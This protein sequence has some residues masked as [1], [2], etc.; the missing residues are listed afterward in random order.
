MLGSMRAKKKNQTLVWIILGLLV[1]G[2]I[3]FGGAGLGGGIIRSVGQVGDEEI[4]TES[5]GQALN[6]AL[7]NLSQQFGR[8]VTAAE[9]Q[10]FG[11]Q[12]Q[13]LQGLLTTAA[14]DNENNRLGISIG[15]QAVRAELLNTSAFQG[16]DGSFDKASYEFALER[17]NLTPS[18]YEVILRKQ[19]ARAFLQAAIVAG[20]KTQGTQTQALL[21]FDRETRDFTWAELTADTLGAPVAAPTDAQIQAQYEATPEAYTAPL[22]RKITYVWLTPD[23][24]ADQ[25][26]V[27]E[28]LIQESY[29]LQSDRFNKPEQRSLERIIFGSEQEAIEAR[30]LLDAGSATFDTIAADRGLA[31]GDLDLGEVTRGTIST[32]A[33]K[34]VFDT[35]AT[36]IVGPVKSSLGPALFRINAILAEDITPYEDARAEILGELAGEAARRLVSELVTDIDDLLAAGD[37]L[38]V[39]ATDTDMQL[40]EISFTADTSDG[41]AAYENFRTAANQSQKGDFPEIVDLADGGIFSLRVDAVIE[42][43]LRPL[44]TVKDQVIADWKRAETLRLLTAKAEQLKTDIEAGASFGSLVTHPEVAAR[45]SAFIEAIPSS[46]ITRIFETGTGKAIVVA[47][48]TSVFVARLTQVNAFDGS[49]EQNTALRD[50]VQKQLDAQLGS[51]LLAVFANA[52]RDTADV[53]INQP[54]INQI[55]TQL[56]GGYAGGGM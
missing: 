42:P 41:I 54:A 36:G 18:E 4:T 25:V 56:T 23:M 12:D 10:A 15:D 3:G 5:Y 46:L 9:A 2:L 6:A 49:T 35:D 52:L 21:A 47:G 27:D 29:D 1:L 11:V 43:A 55:N 14:L 51:D 17:A 30:N 22:T 40:G 33:A 39:L 50:A 20:V 37:T 53:S 19:A 44:D 38:E 7:S 24:L 13:V 16:L 45:R 31:P 32:E 34:L 26:D 48:D 8:N 28:A